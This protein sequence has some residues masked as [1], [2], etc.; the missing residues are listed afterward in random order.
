MEYT[1]FSWLNKHILT[2]AQPIL[3]GK[4][5][6]DLLSKMVAMS[7]MW[8]FPREMCCQCKIQ[9]GFQRLSMKTN[10]TYLINTFYINYVLK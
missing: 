4:F 9:A 5:Y 3:N 6:Q 10:V 1:K 2:L 7:H 8:P